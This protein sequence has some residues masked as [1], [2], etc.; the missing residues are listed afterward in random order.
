MAI[1]GNLFMYLSQKTEGLFCFST[2]ARGAGL[3]PSLAPWKAY[4]VLRPDQTPPRGLSRPAIE[5]GVKKNGYQLWR[6][7]PKRAATAT[8]N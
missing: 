4:G 8:K 2:D 1:S 3:P 6:E 5:A 7:K